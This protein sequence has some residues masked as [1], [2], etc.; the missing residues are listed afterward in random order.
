MVD[1]CPGFL[2]SG[3]TVLG[4]DL[5]R[6][7]QGPPEPHFVGSLLVQPPFLFPTCASW[8]HLPDKLLV[9]KSLSQALL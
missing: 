6:L 4:C 3:G 7:S 1:K 9:P 5:H 8:D 2:S